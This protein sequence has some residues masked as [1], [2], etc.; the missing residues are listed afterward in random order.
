M[1]WIQTIPLSEA[2]ERLIESTP[3]QTIYRVADALGVGRE[4]A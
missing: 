4:P 3:T 2:D 1:T